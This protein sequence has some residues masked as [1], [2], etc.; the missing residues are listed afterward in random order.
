MTIDLVI[1]TY[2]PTKTFFDLVDKM[3][4]QTVEIRKIIILNVEQKYFDRLLYATKFIDEHKNV[5][6][7]HISAR[8]FDC[9]KST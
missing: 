4:K 1:T 6:V 3:S 8:E 5:E 2:K 7:R 9:G